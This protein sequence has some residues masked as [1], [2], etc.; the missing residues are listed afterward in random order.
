MLTSKYC[1]FNA[2]F[3]A[4]IVPTNLG[5]KPY[6]DSGVPFKIGFIRSDEQKRSTFQTL[7]H[8]IQ[9]IQFILLD[10]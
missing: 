10:N 4:K 8:L 2:T 9:S 6:Y 5:I 7:E 3:Y 1:K